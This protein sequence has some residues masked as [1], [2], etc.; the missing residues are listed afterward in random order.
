M[1]VLASLV[2]L[3]VVDW[4]AFRSGSYARWIKPGSTAG[5]LVGT[6]KVVA[7]HYDPNRKNVLVIGNSRVAEG[8]SGK[9]ADAAAGR[10]DLHFLNGATPGTS[11]RVWHYMLREIDPDADRFDAIAMMASYDLSEA[12]RLLADNP[13]DTRYLVPFLRLTDLG[14]Y[15]GSFVASEARDAARRGILFPLS[16]LREDIF[17]FASDP[18]ARV[19]AVR[20]RDGPWVKAVANYRGK[21]RSLPQLDFDHATGLPAGN[22]AV[23]KSARTKLRGYFRQI[24]GSPDAAIQQA[25]IEYQTLWLKRIVDRYAANGVPVI[26]FAIPRGP[27]H[28]ELGKPLQVPD[29][30]AAMAASGRLII[31]P[32]DEFKSLEHPSY[33]FDGQHM[34]R[35]GRT[36]FSTILAG[37]IAQLVR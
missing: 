10:D 11:L 25:N 37:R 7:G 5:S 12:P 18:R 27:Y 22:S 13:L 3:A 32:A 30:L 6:T 1:L 17:D 8:F 9:V 15:P 26:V 35:D 34:N 28:A 21:S 16:L 24:H 23:A 29:T 19:D 31:V 4:A 36:E 33:F 2:V 20:T 14:D